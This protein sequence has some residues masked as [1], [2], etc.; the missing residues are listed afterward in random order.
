VEVLGANGEM[1]LREIEAET[2]A[3]LFPLR[4]PAPVEDYVDELVTLG[5][6]MRTPD[7]RRFSLTHTGTRRYN[8]ILALSHG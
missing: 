3:R 4:S 6:I 8:G 1:T 7:G 2:G 5:L